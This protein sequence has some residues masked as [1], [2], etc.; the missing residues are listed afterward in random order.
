MLFNTSQPIFVNEL[1]FYCEQSDK[2]TRRMK[3]LPNHIRDANPFLEFLMDLDALGA[4]QVS[5]GGI[6]Y[7]VIAAR[8]NPRWWLLPLDNG[9]VAI[10]GLEMLQ[11]V[12]RAAK[13]AKTIARLMARFCP[14]YCLGKGTIQFSGLPNLSGAFGSQTVHVAYF[15]GTD[16]PHRKTAIQVMDADGTILGYGKLSRNKVIRPYIRNEAEMLA[17]VANLGLATVDLPRVLALRD[18]S[19]LTMLVT[20]SHKSANLITPLQPGALHLRWLEGLR[21]RTKQVGAAMLLEVLASRLSAVESL[22]GASW[23]NRIN[24]AFGVL[25]PA[26]GDIELCLVH[27]D[28]TPWNSFVQGDR[29]YV[30]DWEYAD[31]SWPVGYDLAHF[32]L[33]TIPPERQLRELPRVLE[34]LAGA[35][36]DHNEGAA[37]RALLLSLVCHSTFYIG[38]LAEVQGALTDWGDGPVR[39]ALIDSLLNESGLGA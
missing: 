33:A 31:P 38:R 26:A 1:V 2:R 34:Y 12:T 32:M 29:L 36:F 25:H 6:A 17:R 39:A 23:V 30:F 27:G 20:D 15:T 13:T 16:G 24:R 9:R 28:F 4:S 22:A 11:P 19:N 35:H 8:S 18:D 3:P 21:L 5:S 7:A 37:R 14:Q 10:A